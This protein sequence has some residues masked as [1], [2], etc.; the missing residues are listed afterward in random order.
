MMQNKA[1]HIDVSASTNITNETK[2]GTKFMLQN[3]K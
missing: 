3:F 2:G 1:Q